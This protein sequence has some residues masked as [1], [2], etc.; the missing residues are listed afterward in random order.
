MACNS[1]CGGG[2]MSSQD[3]TKS[4]KMLR[5]RGCSLKGRGTS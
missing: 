5:V 1:G 2:V 4:F 3:I